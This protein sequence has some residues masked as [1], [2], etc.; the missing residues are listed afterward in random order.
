MSNKDIALETAVAALREHGF[1]PGEQLARDEDLPRFAWHYLAKVSGSG[2]VAVV[3]PR[4][5]ELWLQV[6]TARSTHE[7]RVLDM[8]V[9]RTENGLHTLLQALGLEPTL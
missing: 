8:V 1:V 4:P 3:E 7:C 9:P 5:G 6:F 2:R